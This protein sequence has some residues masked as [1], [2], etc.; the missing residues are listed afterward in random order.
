VAVGKVV[1]AGRRVAFAEG[2]VS[3][4]SGRV[5]ATATST[6]LVFSTEQLGATA[7]AEPAQAS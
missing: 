3:D 6:L 4:A 1:K 7:S 5:V 2:S